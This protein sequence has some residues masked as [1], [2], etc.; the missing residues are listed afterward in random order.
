[1][2]TAKILIVDDQ[3]HALQGVSRIMRGA[4]YE[5]L[6]A[7]TGTECLRLAAEHKPNL[8]LLDVVLPDIDGR[9]VCKRIKSDTET[10]DI[11]V[12]LFSSVHIE[13]DIQ[14]EGLEQGA[15]G[16]IARP[17]SNREL[18]ARVK[19][20]LRLKYAE[21]QLRQ[22]EDLFRSMF[23]NHNA[24]MLLIEP[25]GGRIVNANHAA[26]QF[27][28]YTVSQLCSMYIPEINILPPEEVEALRLLA[29]KGQRN[30]FV[31][32]HRL[33]SGEIRT[34]EVYSSPIKQNR[35]TVLFSI[36]HDITDKKMAEE[37][38]KKSEERYRT[39]ANFTYEWEYWLDAKGHFLYCSPSCERITG[40]SAK[41]FIEDPD[42]MNR[43]IHPD[44][45]NEMLDHHHNVRQID[46]HALGKMDFRIICRD[47]EQRWIAHVCQPVY[48]QEGQLLGRRGSNR[49]ITERK[50]AEIS[51]R[52]RESHLRSLMETIPD[53]LVIYDDLGKVTFVNRA[54]EE[55][56]GWSM[57]ELT[58]KPLINFVPPSEEAVTTEAWVRTLR[59]D[60]VLFETQRLNKEGQALDLQLSTAIMRNV[61]GKHIAS[62]VIHRD[63][64]ERKRAENALKESER[65]SAQIIEFLPDATMVIDV[66]GKLIAW[67]QAMENLTGIEASSMI[68]K[69][70][71]EY[72][73]PFYGQRRPVMLDLVIKHDQE[74]SSKYVYFRG[75]GDRLVSETC[76]PDFCG[77][78][79]T[80][81]WNI[82]APLY[83][84]DGRVVGAIEA[85]RD[86]TDH[87]RAEKQLQES[88]EKFRSLFEDSIDGIFITEVKGTLVD[89]NQSFLDLFGYTKEEILRT[90]VI[91]MYANPADRDRFREDIEKYG[92]IKEYPLRLV[93][94]DGA[95]MDCLF[96]ATIRKAI[97]GKILG[98]R[99]I[100]RDITELK[101]SADALALSEKKHRELYENMPDGIAAVSIEGKITSFNRAFKEMLGG[102]EDEEIYNFTFEDITPSEWHQ[103]ER[104]IIQNQVLKR[105]YSDVYE[106]EY[107][108]KDGTTFP[109]EL[110][111]HIILDD[112]GHNNGM[113]AFVRDISKTV[114]LQKQLLQAQK[115]EAVGTLAGGIAHDFNNLLQVILGYSELMLQRKDKGQP[116]YDALKKINQAGKLGADLVGGLLTFSRQVETRHILVNLNNEIIQMQHLLSRTIPKTIKIDLRLSE[117]I[118]PIKADPSQ[119]GQVLMNLG[120]N[121]RDAMP[122]G[123]TLTIET[124]NVQLDRE[125]CSAHIDA[126][127][128][129]YVL[130]TASDTGQ[131]M[132]RKTLAHI[133]EPFFSTKE[134]GKGTG[135]GLTTVYGVIKQHD[136]HIMCYSEVGHGTTFKIYLPAIHTSK[137]L[138]T[139]ISE[140][141][142]LGGTET[143]LLVDDDDDV[144]ELCQELLSSFGYKVVTASDG[145]EALEIYQVEKDRIDLIML[146][147]IM[148]IMDG[149]KCLEE[150]LH[151]NPNAKVFIASGYSEGGRAKWRHSGRSK[152]IRPKT[153]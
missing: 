148:P 44:H 103:K 28:G 37:D 116:D 75:E 58:G 142:I 27:Y 139:P 99:G 55:L 132:D 38:L 34:V 144:R 48:S 6:E 136:G 45:R 39:V 98:Y 17:I 113:W 53:A 33:A 94:K 59:G 89:A 88:E 13:P 68:G 56:Y 93:K 24:V 62:I 135:L 110:R 46:P 143:V 112:S 4:G 36:I 11:Y 22:S 121:A 102:Y 41:E 35:E 127:P 69:G 133:F 61:D 82:A 92:F 30:H 50:Q 138:E 152:G 15:D 12:V 60:K 74:T 100:I 111:T 77:R 67:N 51:L 72:A 78:G 52:D 1:M 128:G 76:L 47:G 32:P 108:K 119:L 65:R 9:E 95:E 105:G 107:V 19:S 109:V 21:N 123:G 26:E 80:W 96:N 49:D 20:I 151:I 141:T 115:M 8:I 124:S 81:L 71:Y 91:K 131:G 5:V 57:E 79:P 149:K 106:K 14:A 54:F 101:R 150:I 140:T 29:T 122:D 85:I 18:L 134:V 16:Y 120:L 97:D 64:T 114:D 130:L 70:D 104:N 83:D 2:D 126:I 86:I 129:S 147:L 31:F 145:K 3:I 118:E 7:S 125:Y 137:E 90:S 43:I 84:E 10:S 73:L 153:V 40:Y 66:Q 87:K 63:I 42:L 25:E 146:D 117:D 23:E